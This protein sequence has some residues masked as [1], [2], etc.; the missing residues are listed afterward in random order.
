VIQRLIKDVQNS[1]IGKMNEDFKPEL[2]N[3]WNLQ[4]QE[5]AKKIIFYWH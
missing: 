4:K 2:Y 1:K 5:K 3:I